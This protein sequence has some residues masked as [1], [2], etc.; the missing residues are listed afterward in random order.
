MSDQRRHIMTFIRASVLRSNGTNPN[1][2]A[3]LRRRAARA[4]ARVTAVRTIVQSVNVP[5]GTTQKIARIV[6]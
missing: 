5:N 6:K 1:T 3:M 4:E 2:V